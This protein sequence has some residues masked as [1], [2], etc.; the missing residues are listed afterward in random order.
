M[1]F[2]V[3]KKSNFTKFDFVAFFFIIKQLKKK[4]KKRLNYPTE[5]LRITLMYG[6]SENIEKNAN[7]NNF[8]RAWGQL[9]L[10]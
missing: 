9:D 5:V 8:F 4:I 1:K 3:K 2:L 6:S 7:S 10:V